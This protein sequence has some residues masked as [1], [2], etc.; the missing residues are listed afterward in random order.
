M[1]K[2]MTEVIRE[3]EEKQR[4]A[5]LA[6]NGKNAHVTESVYEELVWAIGVLGSQLVEQKKFMGFLLLVL[7][8]SYRLRH[9]TLR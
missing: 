7:F 5:S 3:L 4:A 9:Q 6:V 2:T 8:S 1:M